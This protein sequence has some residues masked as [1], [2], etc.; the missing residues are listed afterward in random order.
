M[1]LKAVYPESGVGEDVL[2]FLNAPTGVVLT[3]YSK[4][5]PI[6]SSVVVI[7]VPDGSGLERT[8]SELDEVLLAAL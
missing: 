2:A 8:N 1:G 5:F 6:I 3:V 4:G 7:T